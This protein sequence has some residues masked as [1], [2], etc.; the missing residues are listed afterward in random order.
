[1]KGLT[2]FE[3]YKKIMTWMR[4]ETDH[5]PPPVEVNL[6]PYAECNNRCYF[7]IT[8]RYLVTQR[9]EVG[10]MRKL[11]VIYMIDLINFL[12]K[13]GVKGLCISGGGE[14]TLHEGVWTLPSYARHK[15]LDVALVT[16]MSIMNPALANSMID[17]RWVAMSVNAP[18]AETYH[19][20]AGID[21]FKTVIKNIETVVQ[22]RSIKRS[23]VDL[24]FKYLLLPENQKGIYEACRLAKS[25]GVQDFHVRPVDFE[26]EDIKGH[27][28]LKLNKRLIEEEF[29]RCHEIETDSFHVF[30]ISHKF[31]S[32]FH[33]IQP[34]QKCLATPILMTVLTDGNS[35]ICVDKKMMADYRLG[36]AY[37]NPESILEW[38][39]SQAHRERLLKICPKTDCAGMRC[40]F[41]RYNEQIEQVVENDRMCLSFP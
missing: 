7:C 11:P 39:G 24:C 19:K 32:D 28:K 6:D 23:K 25:L 12:A 5:L 26:R 8:Q 16:N 34:F 37:P 3:Q 4:G 15:G 41:N 9:D 29:E 17:C 2:Y 35:Y 1:M 38:W 21:H 36:S 40:T 10:E 31:D 22:L 18:D 13:W 33:N 27:R 30:T 14:P 20:I